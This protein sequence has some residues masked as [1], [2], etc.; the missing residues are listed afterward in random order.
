MENAYA[1]MMGYS[2]W[3][4]GDQK[5]QPT[6]K[7]LTNEEYT[8]LIETIEKKNAEIQAEKERHQKELDDTV[9]QAREY[10]GEIESNVEIRENE[11]FLMNTRLDEMKTL[12]DNVLR[13]NR[14]RVNA[15]R[16]LVPKKSHSGYV[17]VQ[18]GETSVSTVI[19]NP[20]N[21]KERE[22]VTTRVYKTTLE[23]PYKVSLPIAAL[24]PE[25]LQADKLE[26]KYKIMFPRENY[27]P[28]TYFQKGKDYFVYINHD[29]WNIDD[30]FNMELRAKNYVFRRDWQ[31]GKNGYWELVLW[32]TLPMDIDDN[33]ELVPHPGFDEILDEG[34]IM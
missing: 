33:G 10:I 5:H 6:H 29:H 2:V 12:R 24:D 1:G 28:V 32:H 26:E 3:K 30:A 7:I 23:T 17:L 27:D 15:A 22:R 16:K 11:I 20:E 8:A 19:Q 21:K 25:V 13:I 31:T 34:A 18:Y 9:N 4:E 14:E